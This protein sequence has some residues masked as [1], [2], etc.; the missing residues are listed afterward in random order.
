MVYLRMT[1]LTNGHYK[2][3]RHHRSMLG[4]IFAWYNWVRKHVT[5]KTTPA[6]ASGIALES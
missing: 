5:L 6:V 1:R 3:W 4:L 2:L